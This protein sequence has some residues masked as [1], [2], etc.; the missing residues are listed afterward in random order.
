MGAPYRTRC[1]LQGG[2]AWP[3]LS[4]DNSMYRP[5]RFRS[6]KEVHWAIQWVRNQVAVGRMDAKLAQSV[7]AIGSGESFNARVTPHLDGEARQRLQK[8]LSARRAREK[9]AEQHRETPS[10]ARRVNMEVTESVR[11]MAHAVAA[12]RGVTTSELLEGYLLA[13]YGRLPGRF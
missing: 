2:P 4:M 6:T 3:G 8:S 1:V 7:D 12:A 9:A 13:D 11:A 5:I 10:N